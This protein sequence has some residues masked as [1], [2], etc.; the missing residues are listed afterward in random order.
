[1]L[2]SVIIITLNEE[3][4]LKRT[5]ISARESAKFN[6]GRS[7]PIEIIVSDGGSTD[8]TLEIAKKFADQVINAPR[9][10]YKQLNT[11]VEEANGDVLIFLHA[12]TILPKTGL[13][14]V[15]YRL[16]KDKALIGGG[17]KK[18]W[19]WPSNVKL[20]SFIKGCNYFFA[21]IGNWA[22]R[23]DKNFPG[24][25]AIFV[26]KE[27]FKELDGYSEMWILEGFDF[28]RKMKR[29]T[30][31]QSKW[32]R[33]CHN[34]K[35]IAYTRPAVLTSTRRFETEGFFRVWLSWVIIYFFWR[36][37][38]MPQFRI[39]LY[40]QKYNVVPQENHSEKIIRW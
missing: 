34:L 5:I 20:T 3:K 40:F 28:S 4:N 21:G 29:Y 38:K 16:K 7:F 15:A 18:Y 12:D 33:F 11:A 24:D 35:R 23:L 26:R 14:Q 1:M 39:R 25:N 8:K 31:K 27:I 9:G 10:R 32:P 17:F 13:L 30:K 2:L 36:I 19:D 37:V 6:D 22:L